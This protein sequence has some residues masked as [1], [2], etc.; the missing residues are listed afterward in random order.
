M[1][2]EL[3]ED[4]KALVGAAVE[5]SGDTMVPDEGEPA[6]RQKQKLYNLTQLLELT[7]GVDGLVVECGSFRGLTAY[8]FCRTLAAESPDFKG[9]GVHLFDSFQG[10]SAPTPE[11]ELAAGVPRGKTK[12]GPGMFSASVEVVQTTLAGFPDVTFHPGWLPESL[13]DAP[14]G[15]FRFVHLD[16]DLY[17]PSRG[18]LEFFYPRLAAGGLLVCDDYGSV[19]WP[20]VRT[21]VD[22]FCATHSLRP[23]RLSSGHAVL[24]APPT[25]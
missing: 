12:R 25:S 15:P 18:C 7:Q 3:D 17:D 20:G 4:F 13:T 24:F 9:Q 6:L 21:A 19:R 10:L 23:L 2:F 11:D 8:L 22:D 16:L 14:A 1:H 5:L